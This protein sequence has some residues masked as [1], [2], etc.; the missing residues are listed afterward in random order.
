MHYAFQHVLRTLPIILSLTLVSAVVQSQDASKGEALTKGSLQR[1]Y[2][3][4]L[5][6]EG[7]KPE[8]DEDG[9]VRFKHEGKTYFI[10]VDSSDAECFRLVL[11]NIWPIENE[12]ERDQ[13]RVAMDHC[14]ALAKVA[15][16]YM[17]RD[18]VWVAIET[19][20]PRPEDFKAIFKRSL[21]ALD[22]GVGLFA[23]KM[24]GN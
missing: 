11:A 5:I 23:R 17:V 19:F 2:M 16:A 12:E 4:Y 14:N 1:M 13:V 9:D 6:D 7:Y 8:L 18:D 20:L 15:K 3:D 21:L 10:Q 22:H 24:R